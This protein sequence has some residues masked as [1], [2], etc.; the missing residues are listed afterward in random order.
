MMAAIPE[1]SAVGKSFDINPQYAVFTR[2]PDTGS[3]QTRIIKIVN[4][5]DQAE[6]VFNPLCGRPDFKFELVTVREGKEFDLRV[7]AIASNIFG[8]VSA[9]VTLNT[10]SDKMPALSFLAL[11]L[12]QPWFSLTPSLITL[13]AGPLP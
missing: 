13:P 4:Q 3:N 11:A 12:V 6:T 7:T 9:P 10:S 1:L 8:S 2:P 5:S